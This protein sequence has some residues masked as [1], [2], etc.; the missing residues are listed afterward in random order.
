MKNT[1]KAAV[2]VRKS[3]LP[4]LMGLTLAGGVM[5]IVAQA[6]T[7][8]DS[9][10]MAWNI[11][12]ISTF[13]PAQIGEVVTNEI[14]QNT[15]DSLVDFDPKDES[16]VIPLLAKSWD[17]SADRMT[18]TFHLH[19]GLVFPSGN[20][21]SAKDLAWSLQRVVLLGFGNSATLTEYGFTKDNVKERITAPDDDTLVM[22]LDKPYPTNLVLQAI[23]ANDVAITLDKTLVEKNAVG[24]DMGNKYLTT[25]TACIGPYQLTR[26]NAGEGLVLQANENYYGTKPKLQRILIRHVAETGTQRL[27]LTQGDVDIARDLAP[28][29]LRD[30]DKSGKVNIE[31]VLKPQLFFWT[32]NAED[33]IFKNP[34]VRLAMRYLIDYQGLASTV[35]PYLGVPRASFVQLGAFGALDKQQ[36]QPFKLDLAKAKQLLTEAGYPNGFSAKIYI[37]TLPHSAPIAQNTQENAAKIGVKLSIESMANA[38]LFSRVRGREFQSAMM[39][40]QTSVP[41]A[42]GNASRLVANPDNSKEAKKTQYPSWRASYFDPAMNKQVNAALLEPDDQKRIAL[43]HQLQEEQMQQGPFAIMFQMY[44]TAGLNKNVKNWTWNGFRVYYADASK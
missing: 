27:L 2:I 7:P 23:A 9:L 22:K 40:W 1:R 35:M 38:Q 43:Y 44:N 30:L 25:H 5:P 13:D 31:K 19:S 24:D 6:A 17:V 20:K 34:K 3:L 26:W 12:A 29:D 42:Y 10:V 32:M 33:P 41:D 28:D 11:D 15:C 14:I 21:G 16:K 36:G 18:I 39:A 37:G 8:P 4:M